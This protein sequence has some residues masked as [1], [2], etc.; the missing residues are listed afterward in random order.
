MT[1]KPLARPDDPEQSKRFIEMAREVEA[2]EE[3]GAETFD[4]AFEKVIRSPSVPEV[5]PGK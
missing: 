5:K 3:K 2:D 1:D 4:R